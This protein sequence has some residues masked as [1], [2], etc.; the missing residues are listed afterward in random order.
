MTM[1]SKAQND[2]TLI[3]I[4]VDGFEK[5][6]ILDGAHWRQLPMPDEASSIAKFASL[7]DEATRW[8]GK[9]VLTESGKRRKA[10]WDGLDI[11]QTGLAIHVRVRTPCSMPGG[12][13]RSG[14]TTRSTTFTPG[15]EKKNPKKRKDRST[16]H[17]KTYASPTRAFASPRRRANP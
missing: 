13:M 14:I 15:C 11:R 10:A 12:T 7:V 8:K 2:V 16:G 9:P 4:L 6:E 17:S 1:H 5:N 3:D